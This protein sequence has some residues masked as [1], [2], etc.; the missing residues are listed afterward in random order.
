M[1][2]HFQ[3]TCVEIRFCCKLQQ[4]CCPYYSTFTNWT[5]K[6]CVELNDKHP[7]ISYLI[8]FSEDS[9]TPSSDNIN[10]AM[11]SR[12]DLVYHLIQ[13]AFFAIMAVS[14]LRFKFLWMPHICVVGAGIFCNQAWWRFLF[15]KLL[16]PGIKV[17]TQ[18]ISDVYRIVHC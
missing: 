4:F 7:T 3:L 17:R 1:C 15:S 9:E 6:P 18:L 13:T 14:T 11:K 12:P 8:T 5:T 2:K 10:T 16:M